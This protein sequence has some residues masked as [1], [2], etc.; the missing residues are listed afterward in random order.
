M[1][2]GHDLFKAIAQEPYENRGILH[3]EIALVIHACRRHGIER[4]I[5]SGRARAQSTYMLAKYMPDVEIHS[6]EARND[7]DAQF[8][9]ERVAGMDNVTLYDNTDGALALPAM[10]RQWDDIPTAV[11]CDGPKGIHAVAVVQK[12]F[13]FPH[14]RAGFIHDMRRLDH[15]QPSPFRAAAEA[16]FAKH[17]FSD[18][19][20]FIAGSSWMDAN[21]VA[22]GGPCGPQHEAEFGSY[23]PTIGVF[24]NPQ[25]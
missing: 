24:V 12:C 15:G 3:S 13:K 25:Q 14:V 18:D 2:A 1:L 20:A 5:E 10:C 8:G 17:K 21:V 19:P 23:G 9:R 22:A 6:V 7:P 4:V 11:L 16:V